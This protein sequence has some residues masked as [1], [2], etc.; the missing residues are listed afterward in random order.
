MNKLKNQK[1]NPLDKVADEIQKLTE[2]YDEGQMIYDPMSKEFMTE[3]QFKSRYDN[4]PRANKQL[5]QHLISNSTQMK[6]QR[7][8]FKKAKIE[9]KNKI[10]K[11]IAQRTEPFKTKRD[12]QVPL[13]FD[14]TPTPNFYKIKN[15]NDNTLKKLVDASNKPDPDYFRGIGTFLV[16]KI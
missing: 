4:T 2:K 10:K 13:K 7:E 12:T 3:G 14:T 5:Q 1:I 16:K 9:E 6:K 11:P 15:E 8:Y